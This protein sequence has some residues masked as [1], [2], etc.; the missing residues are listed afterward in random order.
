MSPL[1]LEILS[2]IIES[3]EIYFNLTFHRYPSNVVL[4]DGSFI[5]IGGR[6]VFDY[7]ILP[8]DT[9]K[10]QHKL[11]G[12]QFL[13]ETNDKTAEGRPIENNLY[14]FIFLLPDGNTVIFANNR[15]IIIE[16][17]TG[18]LIRELPVL[19]GGARNYPATGSAVLLPL[20]LG[21]D[22]SENVEVQMLVCGGNSHE[23][24]I[25]VDNVK[26]PQRIYAPALQVYLRILL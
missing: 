18:K 19:P 6:N 10:F 5:I 20:E 4:D 16:P 13:S 7:E 23:A 3:T 15:S 2:T 12:L 21:P 8:P 11:I 17:R 26:E 25:L 14:P 22:N 9:M 24:F 1:E